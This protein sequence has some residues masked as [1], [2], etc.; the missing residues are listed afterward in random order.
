[1]AVTSLEVPFRADVVHRQRHWRWPRW[2]LPFTIG[3]LV[4]GVLAGSAARIAY[5]A[6]YQ[7]L[8][9][10]GGSSGPVT[11]GWK[12]VSDGFATTRWLLTAKP[13]TTATFEY[14]ITNTGNDSVTLYAIPESPS[15][16][17][18]TSYSWATVDD[19]SD[20]H[21]LPVVLHPHQAVE[22][23]LSI[24]KPTTC[25]P[26]GGTT[27]NGLVVPVRAFGFTHT[28]AVPLWQI[29]AEPIEVCW[30]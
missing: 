15:D 13:G 11:G 25:S 6:T 26:G 27:V 24:R 16:W 19:Q 18:Y 23:L 5:A 8:V 14:A 7:P 17:L 2:L 12:P 3:L 4:V 9:F 1:M 30:P 29:G 20:A 22:Y 10:E 21:P 28:L